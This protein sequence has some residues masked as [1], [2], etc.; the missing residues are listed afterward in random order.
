[1]SI[2]PPIARRTRHRVRAR[3]LHVAY[4][5]HIAVNPTCAQRST[6][7]CRVFTLRA[8][9]TA[10]ATAP[11][12][13]GLISGGVQLIRMKPTLALLRLRTRWRVTLFAA[14]SV[15]IVSTA[16]H[17]QSVREAREGPAITVLA[18]GLGGAGTLGRVGDFTGKRAWGPAVKVGMHMPLASPRWGV[19]AS[20]LRSLGSTI[21]I[22]QRDCV[23]RC[24][25]DIDVNVTALTLQLSALLASSPAL[26]GTFLAGLGAKHQSGPSITCGPIEPSCSAAADLSGSQTAATGLVGIRVAAQP[27]R[28]VSPAME[29]TYQPSSYKAGQTRSAAHEISATLGFVLRLR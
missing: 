28:R 24:V 20:L 7:G 13:A 25:S 4:T 10:T 9:R 12:E 15:F 16:A 26:S 2:F 6:R 11:D 5:A 22:R 21:R 3:I 27:L 8:H 1:M 23:D 29:L 19:E 14:C 18:G 17:A